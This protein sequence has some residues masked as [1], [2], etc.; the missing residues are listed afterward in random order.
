MTAASHPPQLWR[1]RPP[2]IRKRNTWDPFLNRSIGRTTASTF[3]ISLPVQNG[4]LCREILWTVL[5]GS[6]IYTNVRLNL[7]LALA[8]CHSISFYLTSSDGMKYCQCLQIE[9]LPH[10]H[11][12]VMSTSRFHFPVCSTI[13]LPFAR[14]SASTCNMTQKMTWFEDPTYSK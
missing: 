9:L 2:E 1:L 7:S 14:I 3:N 6:R 13:P 8:K 11:S 4:F 12:S 10:L 5:G